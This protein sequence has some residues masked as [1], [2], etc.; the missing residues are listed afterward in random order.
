MLSGFRKLFER[1]LYSDDVITMHSN[2]ELRSPF[3]DLNLVKFS[4]L[5]HQSL[6]LKV[7]TISLF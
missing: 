7:R 2:L 5:F 4:L 6:K 1:D 3:L